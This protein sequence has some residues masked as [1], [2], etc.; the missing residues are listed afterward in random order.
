MNSSVDQMLARVKQF[1]RSKSA[2][3]CPDATD[4]ANKGTVAIPGQDPAEADNSLPAAATSTKNGP[5]KP[6]LENDNAQIAGLGAGNKPSTTDG[7]PKE[8]AFTE[9][10][11]PIAKIAALSARVRAAASSVGAPAAPAAPVAQA[12]QAAGTESEEYADEALLNNTLFLAK[13]AQV[14]LSTEKG[15]M[16][17][18]QLIRESAGVETAREIMRKAAAAQVELD[19]RAAYEQYVAE[20]E[21]LQKQAAEQQFQ[22]EVHGFQTWFA[23]LP[24]EEQVEI[25]KRASASAHFHNR[26]EQE[27]VKIASAEGLTEE[28]AMLQIAL[29]KAAFDQ[30]MGDASA[31]L[32]AEEAGAE[33]PV[34]PNGAEG[35]GL[36][37]AAIQEIIAAMVA[38]GELDEATASQLIQQ[39]SQ[40]E[41]A[42]AEEEALPEEVKSASALVD[43]LVT[44]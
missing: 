10:T 44:L 21:Y 19:Q 2:S 9:P 14:I 33:E 31:M 36:D 1:Q 37:V 30:G 8:D 27:V 25:Q 34:I 29:E 3:C 38:S 17:A 13:V 12:K 32:D 18:N 5:A 4:P 24:A 41:G 43:A 7:K 16:I 6:T 42:A 40:E 23:Q 15:T 35:E 26:I 20:Q 22:A 11:T 39:L 28:D